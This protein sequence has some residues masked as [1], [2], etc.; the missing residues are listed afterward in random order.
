MGNKG[1]IAIFK[2]GDMK[3]QF[4]TFTAVPHPDIKI[5]KYLTP[6]MRWI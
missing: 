4:V 3:P 5:S 6:F 1:A 2:G